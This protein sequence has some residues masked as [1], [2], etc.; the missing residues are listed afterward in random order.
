MQAISQRFVPRMVKMYLPWVVRVSP[1]REVRGGVTGETRTGR[2][3]HVSC[4]II[5]SDLCSFFLYKI[6]TNGLTK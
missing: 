2:T 6:C 4:D 1:E 5:F 3:N